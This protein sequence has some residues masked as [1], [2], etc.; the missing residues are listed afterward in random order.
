[1]TKQDPLGNILVVDD[2]PGNLELLMSLLEGNGFTV[3]PA[4][5]GALA[6]ASARSTPPDVILLDIRMPD[7]DGYEVCR[8]LKGDPSTRNIPIIFISALD[9]AIDK[10]KAF[11]VGGD[12]FIT[13]PFQIEEV[14]SRIIT[15]MEIQRLRK[16]DKWHIEKL[17]QLVIEHAQAEKELQTAH[18][19]LTLSNQ[20]LERI[21]ELFRSTLEQLAEIAKHST[22]IDK[23]SDD[24]ETIRAEL[25][26]V[27]ESME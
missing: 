18:N 2:T 19:N 11:G 13:K 16:Q 15:Q 9:E 23:I 21:R 25:D 10:V 27:A 14:T 12:D 8:Q 1:M 6:L 4:V 5:N 3:R 24:I 7:M 26:S 20:Q 17:S 22:S